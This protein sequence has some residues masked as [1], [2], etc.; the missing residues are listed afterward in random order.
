MA[1]QKVCKIHHLPLKYTVETWLDKVTA[2]LN[3]QLPGLDSL[4]A[5]ARTPAI[6]T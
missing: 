5:A 2:R 1:Y 3:L 6:F 4:V